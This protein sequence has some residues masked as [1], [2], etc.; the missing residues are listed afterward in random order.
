R[1][2]SFLLLGTGFLCLSLLTFIWHAASNLGWT[3]VWY[4]AGIGLGTA[5]IAV[6][7]LFEKKRHE[8]I[9]WLEQLKD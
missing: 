6:F 7:A 2:R 1:V 8:M 4:V 5:M 3:W 9:T